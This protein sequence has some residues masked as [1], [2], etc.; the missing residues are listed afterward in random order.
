MNHKYK[1]EQFKE[2]M[3]GSK[4]SFVYAVLSRVIL[5]R[6]FCLIAINTRP[7][8]AGLFYANM[9][10]LQELSFAFH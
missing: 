6:V 1:K 8:V 10:P 7:V 2:K 9:G 5:A 4:H 3:N